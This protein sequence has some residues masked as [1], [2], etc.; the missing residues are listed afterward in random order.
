MYPYSYAFGKSTKTLRHETLAK[1]LENSVLRHP[2]KK[3]IISVHEN[4]EKTFAQLFEDVKK[5]SKSLVL[6]LNVKRGDVIAIMTANCY[7]FVIL[8]YACAY[9]GAILAPINAYYKGPELLHCLKKVNPIALFIPGSGSMQESCVNKFNQV[10]E[11]IKEEIPKSINH[12]VYL[13]GEIDDNNNLFI[14]KLKCRLHLFAELMSR[15]YEHAKFI[16]YQVD[17]DDV[18]ALFFTSVCASNNQFLLNSLES[19]FFNKGHN[20]IFKG[21][22]INTLKS[23]QQHLL[24]W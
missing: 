10:F 2:D 18:A 4:I 15:N 14:N 23:G 11:E 9:V 13:D 8:Q 1:S 24:F 7:N 6:S 16:D 3:A 12:I 5:F 21:C 19:R 17:P 20:W 22:C